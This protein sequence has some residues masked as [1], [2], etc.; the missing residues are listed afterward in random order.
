MVRGARGGVEDQLLVAG[1]VEDAGAAV[2][3]GGERRPGAGKPGV[4]PGL[5]GDPGEPTR[6]RD[7]EGPGAVLPGG[8]GAGLSGP[9]AGGAGADDVA[10]AGRGRARRGAQVLVEDHEMDEGVEG[11]QRLVVGDVLLCLGGGE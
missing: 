3:G 1:A 10:V 9:G 8:D 2:E 5:V 6:V 7:V 4:Q 11:A